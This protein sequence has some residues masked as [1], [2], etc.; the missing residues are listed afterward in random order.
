VLATP[1]SVTA[2]SPVEPIR[3]RHY[4]KRLELAEISTAV[5]ESL[6]LWLG[7]VPWRVEVL[8]GGEKLVSSLTAEEE[9]L[10]WPPDPESSTGTEDVRVEREGC[11]SPDDGRTPGQ[12]V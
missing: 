9:T 12:G 8:Y 10:P 4:W 3:T 7:I 6:K 11:L 1:S 5:A 2:V